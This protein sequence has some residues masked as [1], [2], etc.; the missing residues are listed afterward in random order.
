MLNWSYDKF[1]MIW[2][3]FPVIWY[4]YI[5]III[6]PPAPAVVEIGFVFKIQ[7]LK[8][9]ISHQWW[10]EYDKLNI[11]NIIYIH[12]LYLFLPLHQHCPPSANTLSHQPTN[13]SKIE[14]NV[15]VFFFYF[16]LF[17]DFL[18]EF[19]FYFRFV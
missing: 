11:E 2:S 3:R 4:G 7:K 15:A 6:L 9:T 1:N 16:N 18:V 19:H 12:I 10:R 17:S 5:Q 8:K 13:Q 14:L